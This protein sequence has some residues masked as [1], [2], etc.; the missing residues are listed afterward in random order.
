M[1]GYVRIWGK[2]ASLWILHVQQTL[3]WW[4]AHVWSSWPGWFVICWCLNVSICPLNIVHAMF[5]RDLV[6]Y[7]YLNKSGHIVTNKSTKRQ[8]ELRTYDLEF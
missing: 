4:L 5:Q 2:G 7:I 1:Y 8:F 3:F 6:G